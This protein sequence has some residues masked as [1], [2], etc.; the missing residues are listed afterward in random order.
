MGIWASPSRLTYAAAN[1]QK[2]HR[3]LDIHALPLAEQ[4]LGGS[5]MAIALLTPQRPGLSECL[6]ALLPMECL[7][8]ALNRGSLSADSICGEKSND[9]T[10][11][12]STFHSCASRSRA[13]V[14]S[15]PRCQS[16]VAGKTH[17]L[18]YSRKIDSVWPSTDVVHIDLILD[19]L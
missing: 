4:S 10:P 13:H 3:T 16:F 2:H 11:Y 9:I 6:E 14:C 12:R 19:K 8:P 18:Q 15:S 7:E 1:S 17:S 5:V